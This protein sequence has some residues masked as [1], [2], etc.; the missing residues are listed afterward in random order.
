MTAGRA[1]GAKVGKPV[2]KPDNPA[3][4][5]PRRRNSNAL[6]E[7]GAQRLSSHKTVCQNSTAARLR[8]CFQEAK[9]W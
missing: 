2:R 8:K 4:S 7:Q 5:H 6:A 1:V 3:C 9:H